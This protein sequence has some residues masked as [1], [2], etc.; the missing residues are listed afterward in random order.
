MAIE[1][2]EGWIRTRPRLDEANEVF[3]ATLEHDAVD[4]SD[5]FAI[6]VTYSIKTGDGGLVMGG[7]L[8]DST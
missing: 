5:V 4:R 8:T 2:R 3:R 6:G 7:G 1:P